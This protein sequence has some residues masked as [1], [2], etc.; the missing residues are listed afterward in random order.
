MRREAVGSDE[1]CHGVLAP[2]AAY[3]DLIVPGPCKR[4]TGMSRPDA[5]IDITDADA[6]RRSAARR[7]TWA[8]LLKRV[9]AIDVLECPS[10]GGRR[11]LIALISDGPLVRKILETDMSSRLAA[12]RDG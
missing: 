9:F 11:E 10:C 2:A 6:K 1:S 12:A 4:A 7:L 5:S 3:R 8:E